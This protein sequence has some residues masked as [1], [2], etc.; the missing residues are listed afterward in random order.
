MV[1]V[2]NS[3]VREAR[4]R[5]A[6]GGNAR[7][8]DLLRHRR[9]RRRLL[10]QPRRAPRARPARHVLRALQVA[11]PQ[12]PGPSDF[13]RS[14][15]ARATQYN[16][17]RGE[18]LER[19]SSAARPTPSRARVLAFDGGDAR[20]S[21]RPSRA[22]SDGAKLL[23]DYAPTAPA[24]ADAPD[25]RKR[26]TLHFF[27][28]G[29]RRVRRSTASTSRDGA[30]DSV[31][32]VRIRRAAAQSPPLVRK[33]RLAGASIG[34]ERRERAQN[35]AGTEVERRKLRRILKRIPAAFE[36]GTAARQ[37]P[38]QERLEGRPLRAHERAAA[39]GHRR[40]RDLPRPQRQQDRG[41][42]RRALDHR[43]APGREKA[44][45]G[46]GV[47][48]PRGNEDF[49]EFFGQILLG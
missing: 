17:H 24:A 37:G 11:Q 45:P 44:K 34:P 3:I 9:P 31:N 43:P 6:G 41:A 1:E 30:S 39:R 38:H 35:V 14:P 10:L 4:A 33:A 18:V 2:E 49:D 21:S 40:P 20:S 8:D 26:F 23:A 32:D 27:R 13:R 7:K 29:R 28:Q 12:G 47:H 36:A 16:A 19:A 25:Q 5:V 15:P 22:G 46:F 48:I 42:R